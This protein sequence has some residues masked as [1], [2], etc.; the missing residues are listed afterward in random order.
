MDVRDEKAMQEQ[1]WELQRKCHD[2]DVGLYN[3]FK[4]SRADGRDQRLTDK[5]Y[6]CRYFVLDLNHDQHAKAA[7]EAYASS[8]ESEFPKLA[9]DLRNQIRGNAKNVG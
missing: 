3:K 2:H 6:G 8:C 5:H 4:V 1:E 9:E 7:I